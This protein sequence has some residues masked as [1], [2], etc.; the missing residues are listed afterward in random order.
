[1]QYN[2]FQCVFISLLQF[3][4][5]SRNERFSGFVREASDIFCALEVFQDFLD[6]LDFYFPAILFDCMS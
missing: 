6:F 1:M 4:S 2:I 3:E 5:I